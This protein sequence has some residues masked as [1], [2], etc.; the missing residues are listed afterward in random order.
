MRIVV[1]YKWAANPADADVDESGA[2]DWSRAPAGIGEYDEVALDVARRLADATGAELVGLTLGPSEAASSKATKA[3]LSRGPDRLVVLADEEYAGLP[4]AATAALLAAAIRD[5]A[6]VD[7][8][9]T[10][11]SSL[12]EGAQLVGPTMAG[13]LGWP[14]LAEVSQIDAH[15]V[16]TGVDITRSVRGGVHT[17]RLA[18]PAVVACSADAAVPRIPG[19][20]D[21]LAAAKKQVETRTAADL[22]VP[23]SATQL[24]QIASRRPDGPARRGVLISGDDP[25]TAARTVVAALRDHGVLA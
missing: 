1:T 24:T 20:K 10:G 7:L 13:L 5:L 12:D 16:R 21:V 18:L 2:V 11:D 19:M 9:I 15:E 22:P 23:A 14:C 17:L 25:S 8:V 3:A 4:T 6:P